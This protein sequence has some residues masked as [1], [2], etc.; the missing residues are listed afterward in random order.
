MLVALIAT[1][2]FPVTQKEFNIVKTEIARRK[3]EDQSTATAEEIAV[4]EKVTGY[5]YDELWNPAR[6]YTLKVD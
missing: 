4:C 6:A 1:R 5:R 2:L 3:G